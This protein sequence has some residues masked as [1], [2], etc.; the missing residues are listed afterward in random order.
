MKRALSL[1]KKKKKNFLLNV[2]S[3]LC[4]YCSFLNRAGLGEYLILLLLY[5]SFQIFF[6]CR[7]THCLANDHTVDILRM[8]ISLHN[9]QS[10]VSSLT[11]NPYCKRLKRISPAQ[12]DFCYAVVFSFCI[13]F[14]WFSVKTR[15]PNN[16]PQLLTT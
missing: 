2:F 12:R 8:V 16:L 5:S 4:L 10:L 3:H 13:A 9:M 11:E 1:K 14:H 6:W 15:S 7:Y